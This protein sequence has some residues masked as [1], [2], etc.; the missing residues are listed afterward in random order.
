MILYH[1]TPN[2]FSSFDTFPAFFTPDADAALAYAKGQFARDNDQSGSGPNI[3]PVYLSILNPKIYTE[4]ELQSALGTYDDGLIEWANFDEVSYALIA[5]GYDG[6]IIKDAL[7]YSGGDRLNVERRR[8][9][10]YVVFNAQQIK[11]ALGNNGSFNAMSPDIRFSMGNATD[12]FKTWF[13]KSKVVDSK[14]NPLQ[15]YHGTQSDFSSFDPEM[16]GDTVSSQDVGFFFTNYPKEADCYAELDWDREDPRPNVIPAYLS[17]QNPKFIDIGGAV[18]PGESPGVW[19]DEYGSD[20]AVK[21]IED[22]YDGLIITDMRSPILMVDGTKQSLFVAFEPSQIKSSIGNNGLFDPQNTDI[23]FSIADDA[24]ETPESLNFQDWVKD[25]RVVDEEGEPLRLYHGTVFGFDRFS[26]QEGSHLGFHFGSAQQAG[27]RLSQRGKNKEGCASGV[28]ASIPNYVGP[29]ILPVYLNIKRPLN[30]R[31]AGDWSNPFSAWMTLNKATN[32]SL[33]GLLKDMISDAP[34]QVRLKMLVDKIKELGFDGVVY[35]N[36]IEGPGYSWIA[37]E[38][39]QIRSAM[40]AHLEELAFFDGKG[41][42]Y[43]CHVPSMDKDNPTH[44]GKD[45]AKEFNV[46]DVI[47]V[48]YS[49]GYQRTMEKSLKADQ[50]SVSRSDMIFGG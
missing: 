25:S 11:S 32:S 49:A 19:Y 33:N 38:D 42:V 5:Q 39:T 6:V 41:G 48:E 21:A 17:L 8:Y 40:H 45:V 24:K 15:V 47:P 26:A 31:D 23:R 3:M 4:R 13:D 10:Q 30:C 35:Q 9:D 44:D 14:G 36:K 29:H 2:D 46:R 50:K 20:V 22:G 12:N 18:Q 7:D 16:Q 43:F 27:K 37:F 28:D 34:R 1:G